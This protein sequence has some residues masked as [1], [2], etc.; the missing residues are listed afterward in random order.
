MTWRVIAWDNLWTPIA[1]LKALKSEVQYATRVSCFDCI[2]LPFLLA[3][4][5]PGVAEAKA[6]L[7]LASRLHQL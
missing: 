2:P 5:G 3:S 7:L 6:G 4:F 1:E